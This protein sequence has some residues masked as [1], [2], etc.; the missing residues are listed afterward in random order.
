M[1]T[2]NPRGQQYFSTGPK[3]NTKTQVRRASAL[4]TYTTNQLRPSFRPALS[5]P[6]QLH[7][8]LEATKTMVAVSLDLWKRYTH[9]WCNFYEVAN[10][11]K[12]GWWLVCSYFTYLVYKNTT[13]CYHM[14]L[15]QPSGKDRPST[16]VQNA[17]HIQKNPE[18]PSLKIQPCKKFVRGKWKMFKLTF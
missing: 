6:L 13:L 14:W 1:H 16:D 12:L 15:H 17:L 5:H 4:A 2:H 9:S 3:G 10:M 18:I 7:L 8:V 11:C